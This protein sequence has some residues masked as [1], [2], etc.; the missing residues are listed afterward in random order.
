MVCGPVESAL[1]VN[2]ATPVESIDAEPRRLA[3]STKLT[4]PVGAVLPGELFDT[5]AVKVTLSPCV[6]GLADD[7]SA[8]DVD[9]AVTDCESGAELLPA[10]FVSV[11]VNV[12][13][14]EC[15]ATASN[16]V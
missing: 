14:I 6:E 3:P 1:V 15:D 16:E 11:L 9:A 12:A 4:T 5:V 8:V 2:F 13:V 10:T 7:V